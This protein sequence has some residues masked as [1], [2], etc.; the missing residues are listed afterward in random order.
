VPAPFLNHTDLELMTIE[1]I[2]GRE[3][4]FGLTGSEYEGPQRDY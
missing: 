3:V 1:A 4:P 2:V